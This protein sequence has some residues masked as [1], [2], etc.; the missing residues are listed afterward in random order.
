MKD[1]PEI[2][3]NDDLSNTSAYSPKRRPIGSGSK[4]PLSFV[5]VVLLVFVLAGSILY[6]L[7]RQPSGNKANILESKVLALEEKIVELQ[8]QLAEIQGKVSA[9]G[10]DPALLQR[11]DALAQKVESLEKQRQPIAES[12]AKPSAP[13]KKAASAEKRYHTVQKGEDLPRISKKYGI[14]V[15]ELRKLN[16]LPAG[17]PLRAGQ[18][19]VVS[20]GR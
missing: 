4:K 14:S 1:D 7:S 13:P 17:K 2:Q 10:Q 9:S 15:E 19:L 5:L 6:F 20:S 11:L 8:K 18:K 16:N 3:T 12:K